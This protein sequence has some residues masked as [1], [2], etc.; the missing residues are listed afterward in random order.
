MKD[1][2]LWFKDVVKEVRKWNED[3]IKDMNGN[4]VMLG[5][6]IFSPKIRDWIS[7]NPHSIS[8]KSGD[9]SNSDYNAKELLRELYFFKKEI[10]ND[11]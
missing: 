10:E 8:L 11:E 9:V 3:F 1:T 4:D 7:L 2:W 6:T 5:I